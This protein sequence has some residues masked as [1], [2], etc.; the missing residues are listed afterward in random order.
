[1]IDIHETCGVLDPDAPCRTYRNSISHDDKCVHCGNDFVT[2][3]VT[4]GRQ[5]IVTRP[6][7]Y[8]RKIRPRKTNAKTGRN[9]K[10]PCNSDK[11]FKNCCYKPK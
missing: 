2:H 7:K 9:D 11:K 3:R 4:H 5:L 8:K 6:P 1:M 10:C